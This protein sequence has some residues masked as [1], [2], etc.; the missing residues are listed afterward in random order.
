MQVL[1]QKM[2]HAPVGWER[3]EA[4]AGKGTVT[5]WNIRLLSSRQWGNTEPEE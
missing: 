2:S 1:S 4:V 5:S 3:L